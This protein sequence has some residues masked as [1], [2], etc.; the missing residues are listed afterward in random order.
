[1]SLDREILIH[2]R[3]NTLGGYD[4]SEGL[5]IDQPDWFREGREEPPEPRLLGAEFVA[6]VEEL[7]DLGCQAWEVARALDVPLPSLDRR[8]D[9]WGRHD[10]A[11]WVRAETTRIGRGGQS[12]FT[13]YRKD[14]A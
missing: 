4:W 10:L 14:A 2:R 5:F 1:M 9:R 3:L 13:V 12:D 11:A 8:L 7:K 6:E